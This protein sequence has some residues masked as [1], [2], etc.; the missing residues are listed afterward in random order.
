MQKIY[1]GHSSQ[2][3]Y[4]AELYTPLKISIF[5]QRYQFFLPHDNLVVPTNSKKIIAHSNLFIAEVSYPSTGLGI[6]LG[7]AS[8]L[9]V[10]IIC[11]HRKD[12]QPSSSLKFISKNIVEYITPG[13]MI[14]KL[15]DLL[16]H[17]T[18]VW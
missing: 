3:N 14:M 13:D 8:D 6:E 1:V 4:Q 18:K 11:I 12:C 2:F 15:E 10:R 17:F 7:W 9:N 5:Y 16:N